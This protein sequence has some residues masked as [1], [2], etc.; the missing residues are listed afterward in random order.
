MRRIIIP[1]VAVALLALTVSCGNVD[2]DASGSGGS[3]GGAGAGGSGASGGSAGGSGGVVGVTETDKVDLLLVVDNSMSM[4]DKQALL[5]ATLPRLVQ[6]L[7]KPR[8]L[9]AAGQPTG[10]TAPCAAGSQPELPPVTDMH[11]GVITSSLGGHGGNVCQDQPPFN[12]RARLLPSVRPAEGLPGESSGFVSFQASDDPG[13]LVADVA[14]HVEAAGEQGCGF[15]APLESMY[16]FLADPS[17]PAAVTQEGGRTV[18]SGVDDTLLAQR[19]AFLRPDSLLAIVMLSDENDC[20]IKDSE[21]GWYVSTIMSPSNTAYALAR[22]TAH[23]AT[24]PNS[25]CCRSCLTSESA[26]PAGCTPLDL[27]PECAKGE[28]LDPAT[29]DKVN[30]RCWDQKQRF[31]I[32]FL[33]PTARYVNALR[34]KQLCTSRDDLLDAGCPAGD[35]V[36][37]P[38][39]A[40]SPN[41]SSELVLLLGIVGVPWQDLATPETLADPTEL[42]LMTANE[43]AAT[44]RWAWITGDSVTPPEDPLMIEST[45]PRTGQNPATGAALASPEAA[46]GANPMNGHEWYADATINGDLQYACIFQLETPRDCLTIASTCDCKQPGMPAPPLC[47]APGSGA[48]QGYSSMQHYAKAYPGLRQLAVLRDLGTTAVPASACPKSIEPASPVYG[49]GPAFDALL[50]AVAPRLIA[51]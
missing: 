23:C 5:A 41:R 31:G 50:R 17:P 14:T 9:D 30:V 51:E 33:H 34:Q 13:Q 48:G 7:V 10:T 19:Q 32:D 43:L 45:A 42:Q 35:L 36:D 25:A 24:D 22:P 12:D 26:P 6:R 29:E 46:Q 44:G 18:A 40:G 4:A 15:E 39:Y 37:N 1:G 38:L 21:L 16:R 11:V 2:R 28:T 49:Y 27:D 3:S 8:C 47:Q 20:S